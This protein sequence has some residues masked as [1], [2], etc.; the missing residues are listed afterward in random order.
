[1]LRDISSS[2][3]KDNEGSTKT[4]RRRDVPGEPVCLSTAVEP[5][6]ATGKDYSRL[7]RGG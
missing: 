2:S 7:S 6:A 5:L 1:M 3:D 4:L